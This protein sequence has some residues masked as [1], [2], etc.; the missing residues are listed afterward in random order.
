MVDS[1]KYEILQ[2][3]F[4]ISRLS[5]KILFIGDTGVGKSKLLQKAIKGIYDEF[6][7]ATEGFE[8]FIF[9]IK[10][11][12]EVI[13]LELK[14]TCGKEMY[15]PSITSFY[16]YANL[17]VISYAIDNKESFNHI[18]SWLEESKSECN[19]KCKFFLIGNKKD[20]ESEREVSKEDGEKFAKENK[21][22]FFA[23]TSSKNGINTQY[24]LIQ[25]AKILYLPFFIKDFEEKQKGDGKKK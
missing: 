5:F 20:L 1:I 15:K 25:A 19:N 11:E 7:S 3:D 10:L 13:N 18:S 21:F 14:D 24:I 17:I 16:K 2:D 6:Y 23:E 12:G 9:N 8:S 22:D 4:S